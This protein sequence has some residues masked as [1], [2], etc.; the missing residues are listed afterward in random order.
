[1]KKL[2]CVLLVLVALCGCSEQPPTQEEPSYECVYFDEEVTIEARELVRID[3][4]DEKNDDCF[5]CLRLTNHMQENIILSSLMCFEVSSMG[6]ACPRDNAVNAA[7]LAQGIIADYCSADGIV[8][9]G[10]KRE[11]YVYFQADKAATVFEINVAVDYS[12]EKW[13]S[14]E[15]ICDYA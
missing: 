4:G 5:L 3:D 1:M 12:R 2:L 6:K 14:F 9:P 10:G 11:F 8:A 7:S 13:V 15:Y